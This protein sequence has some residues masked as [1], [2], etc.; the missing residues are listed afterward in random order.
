MIEQQKIQALEARIKRIEREK[1]ILKK[2]TA[3]DVRHTEVMRLI[4][5]LS[6]RYRQQELLLIFDLARSTYHS[7][8]KARLRINVK[9]D[10]LKAKVIALHRVSRGSAETRTLVGQLRLAGEMIRRYKV[11][12]LR[13]EAQLVSTQYKHHRYRIAN[14][15]SMI[16]DHH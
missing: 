10:R 3:L 5:R 8:C 16:A 7:R 6:A 11:R 12:S 2:A 9:C 14:Q 13:R 4:K 1:D 15:V